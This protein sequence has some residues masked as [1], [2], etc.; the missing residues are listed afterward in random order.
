M[1]LMLGWGVNCFGL[2]YQSFFIKFTT[3]GSVSEYMKFSKNKPI[4]QYPISWSQYQCKSNFKYSCTGLYNCKT[5]SLFITVYRSKIN[6]INVNQNLIL[7][8][9]KNPQNKVT[10]NFP[11]I[12]YNNILN[13]TRYPNAHAQYHV[14]NIKIGRFS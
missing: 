4:S 1:T 11:D 13:V 3:S 9:H 8:L 7:I 2:H 5:S 12:Q 10:P 6:L 14:F